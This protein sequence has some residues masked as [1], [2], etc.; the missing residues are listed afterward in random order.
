MKIKLTGVFLLFI[1]AQLSTLGQQQNNAF[2]PQIDSLFTHFELLK[3]TGDNF[4][5]VDLRKEKLG[6]L[7]GDNHQE[8]ENNIRRYDAV[9][10]Y[11]WREMDY[12]QQILT[13]SVNHL[14]IVVDSLTNEERLCELMD[15][16]KVSLLL[17]GD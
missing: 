14:F 2:T 8:W 4:P 11:N 6:F 5:V 15:S 17:F 9:T 16:M 7:V 13:D 3:N 1:A 12:K 10:V